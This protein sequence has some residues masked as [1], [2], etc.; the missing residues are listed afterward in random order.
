MPAEVYVYGIEYILFA[1]GAWA[2]VLVAFTFIPIYFRLDIQ[3]VYEVRPDST[4]RRTATRYDAVCTSNT[5]V[6][7]Y[8]LE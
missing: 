2:G 3:S 5:S 8:L 1:V 4:E 7:I 6:S